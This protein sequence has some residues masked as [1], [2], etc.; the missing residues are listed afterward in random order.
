M[1]LRCEIC[2]LVF[3][4]HNKL[5]THSKTDERHKLRYWYTQNR[6][7]AK[8]ITYSVSVPLR[9]YELRSKIKIPIERNR[10]SQNC[11][12][13]SDVFEIEIHDEVKADSS[14]LP[15]YLENDKPFPLVFKQVARFCDYTEPPHKSIICVLKLKIRGQKYQKPKYSLIEVIIRVEKEDL[16]EILGPFKPYCRENREIIRFPNVK[17]QIPRDRLQQQNQLI[18]KTK[19][20]LRKYEIPDKLMESLENMLRG[21]KNFQNLDQNNLSSILKELGLHDAMGTL[22]EGNYVDYFHNVLWIEEHH[23]QKEM[24]R[25]NQKDVTLLTDRRP[26]YGI[27]IPNLS[28]GRPS[29][30]PQD[31]VLIHK[32]NDMFRCAYEGCIEII[33]RDKIYVAAHSRK[34]KYVNKELV[35]V[36]FKINRRPFMLSHRA[37]DQIENQATI[38]TTL[39]P[40]KFKTKPNTTMRLKG[41]DI[42][43]SQPINDQ[44]Y[45]AIKN[46]LENSA[47]PAPYVL[48]GPPGTGKTSTLVTAIYQIW[49][50]SFSSLKKSRI[51]ICA[52]SNSAVDVIVQRL[53]LDT[54]I[55]HEDVMRL[56]AKHRL[57]N[58]ELKDCSVNK[59]YV[60][61]LDKKSIIAATTITAG[62]L[63]DKGIGKGYFDYL[64]IDEAGHATE[65]DILVPLA[66]F[67]G[68]GCCL[69]LSGDPQQLRPVVT[70]PLAVSLG[71][72]ISLLERL[73]SK[74]ELYRRNVNNSSNG[75]GIITKLINNYRSHEQILHIP[76]KNFYHGELKAVGYRKITTLARG[77][78]GLKDPDFPIIF[79]SVNNGNDSREDISPSYFNTDEIK[80]VKQ[81]VDKLL[82]DSWNGYKV[83]EKDIGIITPYRKQVEKIQK[84]LN[85][86]GWSKIE[87]G[88]VEKFQGNE[89]LIIIISTV[90]SSTEQIETDYKFKL[91]FLKDPRRFNVA[92]TRA[93]ALLIVVGNS[94]ILYCDSNWKEFIDYCIEHKSYEG[95]LPSVL[96]SSQVKK[97]RK[98]K[99][100]KK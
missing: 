81:Y 58:P 94:N 19:I 80:I 15:F 82:G 76:N 49:K 40:K 88:S 7:K 95:D 17:Q 74:I 35:H 43:S 18:S 99:K 64:F 91:G 46:I 63:V 73:M 32:R 87:V 72:D 70:S 53:L 5:T 59:I 47:H 77:W 57:A 62:W 54:D 28:E 23:A 44:Q 6:N 37:L 36:E 55:P 93:M 50:K 10:F 24:E 45:Q 39:F 31:Q 22:R 14:E 42:S 34:F 2:D 8:S 83:T 38:S 33:E 96:K 21:R 13:I 4:D 61:D 68:D 9:I 48:F 52:P 100:K 97:K 86:R 3:N 75:Y 66:G 26:L 98:H 60:P 79:R 78:K 30:L 90:R 41:T 84:Y 51:F 69:V 92:L 29:L 85:H 11:S 89:K 16:R 20:F 12:E 1:N 65:T 67:F 71:Y 25:Y 27:N 56:Y